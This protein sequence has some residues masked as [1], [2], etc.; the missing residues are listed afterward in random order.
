M[1]E[2]SLRVENLRKTFGET[3]AVDD[4]T[5]EVRRGEFFSLLGPSGCGK[6]TTLRCIAGLEKP[7]KGKIIIGGREVTDLPPQRRNVGLVF[8]E[9]AVFPHMTVYENIAFGLKIKNLSKDEIHRKILEAAEL[10]NLKEYLNVRG[11]KLAQALMQR[12]ALARSIVV[13]PEVLLLDEPLTLV[14]AKIKETMRRELRRYQKELGMTILHVTHDQLE[15]MMVSDKIAVMCQGKILQIGTPL[16]V[17]DNPNNIFVA[18]F[19]GSPTINLIE[20]RLELQNDE[21]ILSSD[22]ARI[23]LYKVPSEKL[24]NYVGKVVVLGIRPEDIEVSTHPIDRSFAGKIRLIEVSGSKLE[25]IVELDSLTLHVLSPLRMDLGVGQPVYMRIKP[26]KAHVFD[27]TT[28]MN[29]M[30]EEV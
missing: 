2:I 17:Y 14:D 24:I 7:D 11:G 21:L 16:E 28:E 13:Q 10:L 8:Q 15:S 23:L 18:R 9:Y 25:L 30:F 26:A 1:T 19:I 4:I 5:F 20:G 22:E 6:T 29:I 3:V 27:R 12:V